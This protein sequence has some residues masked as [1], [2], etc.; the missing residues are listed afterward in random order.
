MVK[1]SAASGAKTETTLYDKF[2]GADFS[3]DPSQVDESHSPM[4]LNLIADEGGFPEKRPGWRTVAQTEGRINGIYALTVQDTTYWVIHAGSRIMSAGADFAALTVLKEGVNDE[5]STGFVFNAV[6]YI[7]TGA[8]YLSVKVTNGEIACADVSESAYMPRTFISRNPTGGGTALEGVNLLSPKQQN[9]FLADGTGKVYQLSSTDIDSV[10]YVEVNGTQMTDGYTVDTAKGTVTFATAPQ[11]PEDAGGVE[12]ADNVIIRFSKVIAGYADRIKKC[13]AVTQYGVGTSDRIFVS[14]NPDYQNQDW[15]SG[16]NDPTYFPDVGYSVI[17]SEQTAVMGYLHIGDSLA[18][19]KED[20]T[21]DATVFIRT[22]ETDSS[23]NVKFPIRQGVRSIG[24]VSRFG[25]ASLRDDP[26]L[27]SKYGVNAIV[28][29]NVTLERTIKRRSGLVDPKLTAEEGLENAV[30]A[31]WKDW[32]VIAVNGRCYVADSKQ[33]S[34][35]SSLAD[36]FMYEWYY[37]EGIP[38]RVL[39]EHGGALFFGT[40]DGRVCRF[41]D[42]IEGMAKYSDD[43]AAIVAQWATKA[44]DDGDFMRYKTM[45]RRGCGVMC[46]PYTSSSVKISVRTE[47]DFGREIA[48]GVMSIFDFSSLDFSNFAFNTSDSPQIV[49]FNTKVRKY[50]TMQIIVRNDGVNQ[51]FGVYQIEKRFRRMNYVK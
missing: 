48:G 36:N 7:L 22:V 4:P 51:G 42:D 21:Q 31:V 26:L 6:L 34:Y 39:E 29:N 49:A 32:L 44:D 37:W 30:C 19:I 43:G 23:G 5:R 41:N 46:K 28:T 11:K 15:Y 16:S 33:Q 2:K 10:D 12:G 1:Y 47:R 9:D 38:A 35:K 25:F 27:L 20:N 24:G 50:K 17:G 40:D 3:T 13:R 18:I 8:E 14:G 45:V